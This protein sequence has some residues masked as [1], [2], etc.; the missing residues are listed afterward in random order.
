[1]RSLTLGALMLAALALPACSGITMPPGGPAEVPRLT[2]ERVES[3]VRDRLAED[4]EGETRW[5][6]F[7]TTVL[8]DLEV[9]AL[10]PLTASLWHAEVAALLDYGPAPTGVLGYERRRS[11][12]YDLLLMHG[13]EGFSLERFTLK[14]RLLPL[15]ASR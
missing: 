1:M 2:A 11:G 5:S 15:P 6:A 8:Q 3:L 9:V 10:E 7:Q 14:G 12:H 13:P 4:R